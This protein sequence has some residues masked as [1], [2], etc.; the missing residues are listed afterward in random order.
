MEPFLLGVPI[1][2]ALL[3]GAPRLF[4]RGY[5]SDL[6]GTCLA[7]V[8][9][10]PH[11]IGIEDGQ[12]REGFEITCGRG[13]DGP[14]AII[15]HV[16]FLLYFSGLPT[17]VGVTL[18]IMHRHVSHQERRMRR[19]GAGALNHNVPNENN[20]TSPD[21]TDV[22][23]GNSIHSTMRSIVS[24]VKSAFG[25]SSSRSNSNQNNSTSRVVM[26]R[27]RAYTAAFLLT[28]SWYIAI[29]VLRGAGVP[30][31]LA[32]RYLAILVPLQGVGHVLLNIFCHHCILALNTHNSL[33]QHFTFS[34][35]GT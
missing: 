28:W 4:T 22:G 5:N 27:A 7:P 2:I 11:C 23:E 32:L 30:L 33:N 35:F 16:A 12:V 8:Y 25:R 26:D 6:G 20:D 29:V 17:I 34:S 3:F 14:S 15:F 31:P 18:G 13:R 19:Y 10:P 24:S 9:E 21:A 1:V